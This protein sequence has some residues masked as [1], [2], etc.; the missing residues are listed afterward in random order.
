MA[1]GRM[2]AA[3]G[4]AAFEERGGSCRPPPPPPND[5]EAEAIVGASD[6]AT[7]WAS[8]SSKAL[9]MTAFTRLSAVIVVVNDK[10]VTGIEGA[11]GVKGSV[12]D[13]ALLTAAAPAAEEPATT[14]GEELVA[15]F[16]STR[17]PSTRRNQSGA[18]LC[19]DDVPAMASSRKM[20][21]STRMED[22]PGSLSWTSDPSVDAVPL[23]GPGCCVL[24]DDP[25]VS[26]WGDIKKDDADALWWLVALRCVA[27]GGRIGRASA[28]E[29]SCCVPAERAAEASGGSTSSRRRST[30]SG[31]DCRRRP[32]VTTVA[33]IGFHFREKNPGVRQ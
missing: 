15:F 32:L 4:A 2:A 18:A 31:N 20:H 1:T 22:A 27:L 8:H 25:Q 21:A 10:G 5:D 14:L 28:G 16:A 33:A 6:E 13:G 7:H 17:F 9:S 11:G 12:G 3:A 30:M 19:I 23:P 29:G 26:E 24:P